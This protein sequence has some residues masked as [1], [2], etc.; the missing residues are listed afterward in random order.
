MESGNEGEKLPDQEGVL[1]GGDC[2]PRSHAA[3]LAVFLGVVH[4]LFKSE[5]LLTRCKA[6][7]DRS[8]SPG[9]VAGRSLGSPV[10]PAI[11]LKQAAPE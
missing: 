10:L 11:V 8:Q 3:R 1:G 6:P 7:N 4:P 5:C 9:P 2:V